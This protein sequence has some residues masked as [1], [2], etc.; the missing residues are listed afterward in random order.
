[1]QEF[2]NEQ[3]KLVSVLDDS[4]YTNTS[5]P[6]VVQVSLLVRQQLHLIG[7]QFTGVVNDIVAGWC[8]RSLTN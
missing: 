4:W 5:A 3:C 6:I 1:M 2:T 8:D 7:R